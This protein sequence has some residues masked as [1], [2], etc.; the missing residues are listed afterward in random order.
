MYINKEDWALL[1]DV[2][3]YLYKH[4]KTLWHKIWDFNEKMG[5]QRDTNRKQTRERMREKRAID[6]NYGRERKEV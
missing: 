3:M 4:N 6:K 2:E 1:C 5:Q